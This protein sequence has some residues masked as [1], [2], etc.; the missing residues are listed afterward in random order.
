VS[1]F[2]S[3]VIITYNPKVASILIWDRFTVDGL[4]GAVPIAVLLLLLAL[5]TFFLIR[6]LQP[7]RTR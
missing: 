4:G 5:G 3:I 6:V 1:E 7:A 2:G